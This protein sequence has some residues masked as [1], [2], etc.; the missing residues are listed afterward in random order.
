MKTHE[1]FDVDSD[2]T[3]SHDEAKVTYYGAFRGDVGL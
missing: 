2:G 3:V 1:E